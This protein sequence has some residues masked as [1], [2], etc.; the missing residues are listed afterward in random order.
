[1]KFFKLRK[2]VFENLKVNRNFY[3]ATQKLLFFS[4][5]LTVMFTPHSFGQEDS[6]DTV[7]FSS[8]NVVAS[9]IDKSEYEVSH[10]SETLIKINGNINDLSNTGSIID[11]IIF[12]DKEI[13]IEIIGQKQPLPGTKSTYTIT[14]NNLNT[15]TK[16]LDR[17]TFHEQ[18]AVSV[19]SK[20]G[21]VLR[22]NFFGISPGNL[23]YNYEL[24]LYPIFKE[25]QKY[26]IRVIYKDASAEF[27]FI[28]TTSSVTISSDK[29][30]YVLGDNIKI[31]G[32]V[33]RILQSEQFVVVEMFS[34]SKQLVFRNIT[35]VESDGTF[36][37]QIEREFMRSTGKYKITAQP[38][39]L[40]DKY[41]SVQGQV[42]FIIIEIEPPYKPDFRQPTTPIHEQPFIDKT[43]QNPSPSFEFTNFVII[44]VS[45][46]VLILF[47]IIKKFF[48]K[49]FGIA[50]LFKSIKK[51]QAKTSPVKTSPVKTSPVKTSPVKTS[52]VKTSVTNPSLQPRSYVA[53]SSGNTILPVVKR[54]PINTQYVEEIQNPTICFDKPELKNGKI[55]LNSYGL[56]LSWSGGNAIVFQ[57]KSSNRLYAI[58]CFTKK[59]NGLTN[60][61]Y[62]S[63]FLK[64]KNLEFM[65]EYDSS[66]QILVQG[67][68]Y[69]VL[70]T[71]WINGDTLHKFL[72][73][74]N[75]KTKILQ[76]AEKFKELVYRMED[77]KIAHGDL[78][79]G[80][81]MI[82]FD[83]T[84]K[85]ID[86]DG[87]YI[88]QFNGQKSHESGLADYQ[89]PLRK[90]QFDET[91]DRF[92]SYCIYLSLLVIAHKPEIFDKYFDDTNLI[93][94]Q[95]DFEEPFMSKLFKE[96]DTVNDKKIR[97]LSKE[98]KRICGMKDL[99]K[100]PSL[101]EFSS[102]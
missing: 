66:N 102:L 43:V 11:P 36:S 62:L 99:K 80:N 78:Q 22:E 95:K 20:D 25:G 26:T 45:F 84:I 37:T 28:P 76:I 3:L 61:Q 75:N 27:S 79:H 87:M 100:I 69:P 19:I 55:Q 16:G 42:G 77:L 71:Q 50:T 9:Y 93:F 32:K 35:S 57:L 56:P 68:K 31:L 98:F 54:M 6:L 17:G 90:N 15:N 44:L 34:P 38:F 48:L 33:T 97:E 13:L 64:N 91:M 18:L 46:F 88:P 81:I 4:L 72:K 49:S 65:I 82:Q 52:P 67:S 12:N 101:R 5:V 53:S 30:K 94:K 8:N 41:S 10:T 21:T 39:F 83:N 70:V 58:K 73:T 63:Q 2:F 85:L 23:V 7:I 60:Y 24:D 86:Y 96:I 29:S 40:S 1:M 47:L 59:P 51:L 92:S 89:H 14:I 74:K